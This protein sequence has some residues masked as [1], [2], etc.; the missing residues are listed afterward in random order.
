MFGVAGHTGLVRDPGWE[1]VGSPVQPADQ[2]VDQPDELLSA[3]RPLPVWVRGAAIAGALL[4]GAGVLI[5]LVGNE[6]APRVSPQPRHIVVNDPIALCGDGLGPRVAGASGGPR[7]GLRVLLGGAQLQRVDFDTG[8][9]VALHLPRL[10]RD[11]WVDSLSSAGGHRYAATAGTSC[12]FDR[13]RVL[14]VRGDKATP[15]ITGAAPSDFVV[16]ETHAWTVVDPGHRLRPLDGGRSVA[17][18][19]GF[20][21][22]AATHGVIVGNLSQGMDPA[23]I[24]AVRGSNGALQQVSG[25]GSILGAAAGRFVWSA[26]CGPPTHGRCELASAT[27]AG[28]HPRTYRLPRPPGSP[29]GQLSPDGHTLAFTLTRAHVDRYHRQGNPSPASDVAVLDLR[30]GKLT[31][32][33][34]LELPSRYEPQFAFA[35][36]GHWLVITASENDSARLFAWRPG[37]PR[38][39]VSPLGQV[40]SPAPPPV[41]VLSG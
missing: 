27:V 38:P 40:P 18:P 1:V 5:R 7:T 13:R 4:V 15:A 30:S 35:P 41:Q 31:I 24:G 25:I 14:M 2:P 34:G 37:L 11:E 39:V 3:G 20:A 19:A 10:A 6:S 32:V 26:G 16:D 33:P 28:T 8:A 21:P 36:S 29:A 23:E 22:A 9:S 12:G 17:L